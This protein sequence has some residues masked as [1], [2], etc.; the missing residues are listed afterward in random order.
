M[1]N[2][3]KNV[4]DEMVKGAEKL[5]RVFIKLLKLKIVIISIIVV[6]L[7]VLFFSASTYVIV[8]YEAIKDTSNPKNVPGITEGY[9]EKIELDDLG[10]VI[11]EKTPQELWNE[12]IDKGANVDNYL[13][14]PEELMKLVNAEFV[15]KYMDTREDPTVKID[16]ENINDVNSK[17]IQGIVKLKRADAAG[18][19]ENLTYVD[20]TT[21]E[22]YINEYNNTGKEE[23]KEKALKHFTIKKKQTSGGTSNKY[24]GEN[25]EAL[26]NGEGLCWPTES[27]IVTSKFGPRDIE[28]SGASKD[29]KGIDIRGNKTKVYAAAA[30]VVEKSAP[31]G[32]SSSAGNWII[33]DHRKWL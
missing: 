19:V 33:I 9:N 4:F 17:F 28:V 20:E 30:G 32:N 22:S 27:N 5:G 13:D 29:H 8:K 6:M 2:K 14:S 24:D 1:D 16:W 3:E 23:Y 15:T 10:K 11:R 31:L 25:N 7:L 18:G 12:M 26:R 21:F